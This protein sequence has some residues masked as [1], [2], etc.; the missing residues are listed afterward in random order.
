MEVNSALFVIT[1]SISLCSPLFFVV[2]M[3]FGKYRTI[4]AV[5]GAGEEE[6]EPGASEPGRT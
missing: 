6:H 3:L 4:A 1:L 2:G 5:I